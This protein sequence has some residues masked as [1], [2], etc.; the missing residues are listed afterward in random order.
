M[1]NLVSAQVK[2]LNGMLKVENALAQNQLK[3]QLVT[4]SSVSNAKTMLP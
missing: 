1:E 4:Q 2:L 3:F